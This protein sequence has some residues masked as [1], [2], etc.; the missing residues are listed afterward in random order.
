MAR[1]GSSHWS[2][3]AKV[4]HTWRATH[5]GKAILRAYSE[6]FGHERAVKVAGRLPPRP[7]KGRW[8]VATAAEIFLLKC[9]HKEL[10]CVFTSV[11]DKLDRV[12]VQRSELELGD[13]DLEEEDYSEKKHRWAL[14]SCSAVGDPDFWRL[15][16]VTNRNQQWSQKRGGTN[17][18]GCSSGQRFWVRWSWF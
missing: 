2:R 3:I 12:A 18:E 9:G 7:L 8:G 10:S 5:H 13:L 4:I 17:W 16:M 11:F 14:E 15:M 1:A 6:K